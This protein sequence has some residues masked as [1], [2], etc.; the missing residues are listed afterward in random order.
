VYDVGPM[1]GPYYTS[2]DLSGVVENVDYRRGSLVVRDD[3]SGSFVT[4]ALT[5]NDSRF[6]DLRPGDYVE[7]SGSWS[8]GIFQ[9][10]NLGGL[11]D[12][13]T[14]SGYDDGY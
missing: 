10:Y 11:R 5:G 3:N 4:V 12:G 6:G 9:A 14:A 2:G 7:M 1:N 13:G 8:R